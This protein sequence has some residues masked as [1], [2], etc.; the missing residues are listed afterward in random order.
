[1]SRLKEQAFFRNPAGMTWNLASFHT[2][3][4]K[5]VHSNRLGKAAELDAAEERLVLGW[6]PKTMYYD[7][8][9]MLP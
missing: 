9:M 8:T 1:M 4:V 6:E 7:G 2:S 5:C 3:K